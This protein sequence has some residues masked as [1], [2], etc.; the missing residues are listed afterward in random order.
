MWWRFPGKLLWNTQTKTEKD[1][2][3][4]RF[5]GVAYHLPVIQRKHKPFPSSFLC[6]FEIIKNLFHYTDSGWQGMI[7]VVF[8]IG[9][10]IFGTSIWTYP[11]LI[12]SKIKSIKNVIQFL[13]LIKIRIRNTNVMTK[14]M[15]NKCNA[16]F[17][18]TPWSKF[19][20]IYALFF[21]AAM[22]IWPAIST[23]SFCTIFWCFQ[24]VQRL[25]VRVRIWGLEML[26]FREILRTY[27]MD[28]PHSNGAWSF[29]PLNI[30]FKPSVSWNN[31]L[32]WPSKYIWKSW[33]CCSNASHANYWLV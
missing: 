6:F 18:W 26:V 31:F 2:M 11:N 12:L 21:F 7:Q 15:K 19:G 25:N 16:R 23:F 1:L 24:W 3:K 14:K 27:L 32:K 8:D 30:T 13:E 28:G 29:N 20:V 33:W 10:P 5:S 9:T 17:I 4:V 22:L